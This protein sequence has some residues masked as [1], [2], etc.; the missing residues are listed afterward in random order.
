MRDDT[1]DPPYKPQWQNQFITPN[2]DLAPA[3]HGVPQGSVLGPLLFT[4][5]ILPLGHIIHKHGLKYHC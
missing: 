1:E 5:Y 4:I 3:N 2:F